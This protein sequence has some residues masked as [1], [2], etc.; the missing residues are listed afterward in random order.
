MVAVQRDRWDID[1]YYDPDP[2]APGKMYTRFGGFVDGIDRFEP[3]FFGIAPREAISM[4][5]QQRMLLETTWEAME[6]AGLPRERFMGSRT[7][8]FMGVCTDDYIT[9]ERGDL[10]NIDIYLGTGGSRGSTAGRV[11][12]A[13]GLRGPVA[14]ID[15]ACSSSL[16][17]IHQACNSLQLGDCEMALAGGQAPMGGEIGETIIRVGAVHGLQRDGDAMMEPGATSAAKSLVQRVLDQRMLEGET[18][19]LV[20]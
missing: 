18:A 5:P 6:H 3:Q 4:D 15:T 11:A 13:F 17:A 1:D 8:V 14:A 7:G 12:F 19:D 16:V 9:L 2:A 20:G 10:K